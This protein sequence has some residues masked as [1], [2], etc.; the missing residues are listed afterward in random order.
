M[1]KIV[2]TINHEVLLGTKIAVL[3]YAEYR[4]ATKDREW[5]DDHHWDLKKIGISDEIRTF[6]GAVKFLN[7]IYVEVVYVG[8]IVL[9]LKNNKCVLVSKEE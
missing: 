4:L 2:D 8:D 9:Q 3:N 7:L 5:K 6:E 1:Y